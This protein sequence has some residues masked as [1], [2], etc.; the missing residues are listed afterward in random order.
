MFDRL[1]ARVPDSVFVALLAV[2]WWRGL[3]RE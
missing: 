1:V 3:K 2:L